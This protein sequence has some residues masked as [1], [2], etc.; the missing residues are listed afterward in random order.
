[1]SGCFIHSFIPL[2]ILPWGTIVCISLTELKYKPSISSESLQSTALRNSS[3]ST[4]VCVYSC[5]LLFCAPHHWDNHQW[6]ILFWPL[7]VIYEYESVQ[8]QAG[9]KKSEFLNIDSVMYCWREERKWKWRTKARV[10]LVLK[11]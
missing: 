7:K 8:I 11:F 2:S 4:G 10:I 1:M 5:F 3:R 9:R 6:F